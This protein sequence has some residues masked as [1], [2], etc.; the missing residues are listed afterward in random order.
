MGVTGRT[1][2]SLIG[3][4]AM[5]S[6]QLLGLGCYQLLSAD[7]LRRA[8]RVPLGA[9]ELPVERFELTVGEPE[10]G[11]PAIQT[12]RPSCSIAPADQAI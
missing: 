9:I 4:T 12:A 11:C 1:P 2:R 10:Y 3:N 5:R 6:Y 7:Q 8:G